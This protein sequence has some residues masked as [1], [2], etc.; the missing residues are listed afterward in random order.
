MTC[1]SIFDAITSELGLKVLKSTW[2]VEYRIEF[3]T[4]SITGR[5]VEEV[6]ASV[7]NQILTPK[8]K[9]WLS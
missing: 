2:N 4:R 7:N 8:S 1:H 3:D 9:H 5:N 6:I